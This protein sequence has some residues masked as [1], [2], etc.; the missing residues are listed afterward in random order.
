MRAP[1]ELAWP[2]GGDYVLEPQVL[3]DVV[4]RTD[5]RVGADNYAIGVV[6]Y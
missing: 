5:A 4:L 2:D 3:D 6:T 1:G